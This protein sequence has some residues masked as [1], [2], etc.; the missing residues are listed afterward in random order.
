MLAV[1]ADER[2]VYRGTV[3]SEGVLRPYTM[4]ISSLREGRAE[5]ASFLSMLPPLT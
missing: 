5:W 3:G 4:V 2:A 1:G